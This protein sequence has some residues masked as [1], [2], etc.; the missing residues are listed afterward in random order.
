M[1]TILTYLSIEANSLNPD[2][3][4]L[5]VCSW[6]TLFVKEASKTFQQTTFVVIDALRV[7]NMHHNKIPIL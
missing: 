2:Q 1:L 7:N 5:A 6:S 3:T 4:A